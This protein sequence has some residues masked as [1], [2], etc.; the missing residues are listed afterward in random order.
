MWFNCCLLSGCLFDLLFRLLFVVA[1]LF[2]VWCVLIVLL[3]YD[4]LCYGLCLRV[5]GYVV[6]GV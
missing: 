1:G 6:V 2:G 5:A 4:G 3:D